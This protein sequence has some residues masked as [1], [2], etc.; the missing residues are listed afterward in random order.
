M[1]DEQ[2]HVGKE[3][4]AKQVEVR[5]QRSFC[6]ANTVPTGELGLR[7]MIN[8][9]KSMADGSA[10]GGFWQVACEWPRCFFWDL[11]CPNCHV[12][13]ND[14]RARVGHTCKRLEVPRKSQHF[15]PDFRMDMVVFLSLMILIPQIHSNFKAKF[16]RCSFK[17]HVNVRDLF[18]LFFIPY[19]SFQISFVHH[20]SGRGAQR[21]LEVLVT[22]KS[23]HLHPGVAL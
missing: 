21:C 5:M 1:Q 15:Y 13:D 22:G 16:C 19:I 7:I 11:V 12:S 6:L 4:V 10:V 18:E 8:F 3:Q 17:A 20:F 2:T 9:C 23:F 14:L